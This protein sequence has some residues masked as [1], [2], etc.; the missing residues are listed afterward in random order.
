MPKFRK[1]PVVIDAVQLDKAA[2]FPPTDWLSEAIAEGTIYYQGG[3][4]PYWTIKTLEGDYRA[5]PF[6]WIIQGV[7]GELYPCKPGIFSA[8]Y[9][10]AD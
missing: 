6:D 4:K 2:G 3:D 10:P 8:T 5:S 9:E 7:A 1:K